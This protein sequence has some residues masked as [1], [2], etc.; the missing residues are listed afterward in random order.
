VLSY[1][2]VEYLRTLDDMAEFAWSPSRGIPHG[3]HQKLLNV[4]AGVGLG[5]NESYPDLFHLYCGFANGMQV[6]NDYITMAELPDIDFQGKSDLIK[7]MRE[8]A[9]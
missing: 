5:G 6:I 1:G 4:A 3:G 9:E 7:V 8:L 2:L